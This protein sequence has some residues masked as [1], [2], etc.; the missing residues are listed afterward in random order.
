MTYLLVA[1]MWLGFIVTG[2]PWVVG[3]YY[4]LAVELALEDA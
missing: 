3:V 1:L 2:E 4:P